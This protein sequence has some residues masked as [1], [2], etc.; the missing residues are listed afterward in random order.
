MCH[1]FRALRRETL[2]KKSISI[3]RLKLPYTP[4]HARRNRYL[5]KKSISITRL[6]LR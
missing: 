6:K 3:T 5:E 2:E 1:L 4:Q